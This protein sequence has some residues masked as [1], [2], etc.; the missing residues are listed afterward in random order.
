MCF[1]LKFG[2]YSSYSGAYISW[3]DL[4]LA[5]NQ[6]NHQNLD[7]S[8]LTYKFWLIF[9]GMKQKKILEKKILEKKILENSLKNVQNKT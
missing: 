4:F 5:G 7:P 8:M 2:Y 3:P 6:V 1:D 9:I